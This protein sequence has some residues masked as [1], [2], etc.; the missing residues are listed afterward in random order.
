[1]VLIESH[2]LVNDQSL[3]HLCSAHCVTHGGVQDCECDS[4]GEID[5]GLQEWNNF[6]TRV[7]GRYD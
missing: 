7:W 5:V 3:I 1:M 6:S 4:R 2:K